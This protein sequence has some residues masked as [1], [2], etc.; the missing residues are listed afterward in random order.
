[1]LAWIVALSPMNLKTKYAEVFVPLSIV[2]L[3]PCFSFMPIAGIPVL[4]SLANRDKVNVSQS[5]PSTYNDGWS[6]VFVA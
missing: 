3:S 4:V 5:R 1:M 6:S 2:Q